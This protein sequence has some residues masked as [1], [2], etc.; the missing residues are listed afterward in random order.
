[1]LFMQ[2]F[3]KPFSRKACTGGWPTFDPREDEVV[4]RGLTQ[5]SPAAILGGLFDA[6][7][8]IDGADHAIPDSLIW[9][10]YSS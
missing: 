6:S 5:I 9:A 2:Q 1:M 3:S 7:C 4:E 8:S 10:L